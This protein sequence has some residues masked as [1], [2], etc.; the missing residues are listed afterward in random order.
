MNVG[1]S[2]GGNLCRREGVPGRE[3]LAFV[4]GVDIVSHSGIAAFAHL[5][6]NDLCLENDNECRASLRP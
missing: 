3:D 2:I 5:F 4:K 1:V 6:V